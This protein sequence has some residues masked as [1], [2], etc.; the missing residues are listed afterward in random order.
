MHSIFRL[1]AGLTSDRALLIAVDDAHWGDVSSLQV[2][3]H[4]A[5]RID[6]LN[7]TLVV[8]L[9]P[10]EPGSPGSLLDALRQVPGAIHLQ[11]TALSVEAVTT[12]LSARWPQITARACSACR[13][14]TGGNPLLVTELLRALPAPKRPRARRSSQPHCRHWRSGFCAGRRRWLRRH[15]QSHRRW[16]CSAMVQA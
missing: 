12:V 6:D 9:R 16:P 1:T 4:L 7:V 15:R 13:E 3:E 8:A 11:P 14:V 2:L 5:R 10:A